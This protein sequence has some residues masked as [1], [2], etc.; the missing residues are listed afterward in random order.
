[1][2]NENNVLPVSFTGTFYFTN[3]TKDEFTA[4][5]NNVAY[6]FPPLKTS[7]MLMN[8]SPSVIQHIRKKFARELAI[9]CYYQHRDF[10]ALT[11]KNDGI[12]GGASHGAL[13]SEMDLAPFIQRCLEPLPAASVKT[14]VLPKDTEDNYKKNAKG[15][16]VTRVL[17][18]DES[19]LGQGSQMA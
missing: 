12:G 11:K 10:K 3:F 1:M 15:K 4:K 18:P 19:L 14:R 5:W 7:P 9:E 2:D 17:D 6:M 13:Y 8:E 16:N